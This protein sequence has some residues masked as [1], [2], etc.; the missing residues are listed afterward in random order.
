MVLL[1]YGDSNTFGFDPRDPLGG[2]Y[3]AQDRW[4]NLLA[5]KTGWDIRNL[6]QNGRT[7]PRSPFHWDSL[8]RCLEANEPA[9]LA[10]MLGTN[11]LLQ[12]DSPERICH[13]MEAFLKQLLP[14]SSKLLLIAPPP[15]GRGT[16]TANP[17]LLAASA[18]LGEQYQALAKQL[19]VFF[20]DASQWHIPLAFDGVHFTEQGHH[21]FAAGFYQ[22]LQQHLSELALRESPAP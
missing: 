21:N 19:G 22:W 11:D 15:L 3:P 8:K 14:L 20:V 9:L 2:Q 5:E 1:C 17:S 12:G 6:G 10:V 13:H 7:I 16:W 4:V 18:A